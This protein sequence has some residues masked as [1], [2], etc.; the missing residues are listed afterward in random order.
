MSVPNV[1]HAILSS[2]GDFTSFSFAS[3]TI[4]FRT[5]SSLDRYISV[6]EWDHGYLVVTAK[7][8]NL[9][10]EEEEY[11]DLTPILQ[12]LYFDAESFLAPIKKVN[13]HY[14]N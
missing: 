14:D 2:S 1:S 8:R 10:D 13:I 12:N 11:I 3:H 6:K 4:R 7:Y 9:P 5:S